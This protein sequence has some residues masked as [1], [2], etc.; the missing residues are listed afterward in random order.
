MKRGFLREHYWLSGVLQRIIDIAA[1]LIAAKVAFLCA[2]YNGVPSDEVLPNYSLLTFSTVILTIVIFT[3][4]DV[5]RG[6]RGMSKGDELRALLSA[7]FAVFGVLACIG[8]ATKTGDQYSR[9]WIALW[10]LLGTAFLAV[11]RIVQRFFVE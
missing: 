5:Y 4:F 10:L 7:W 9:V 1:I 6:W 2:F 8:F 11:F 3:R